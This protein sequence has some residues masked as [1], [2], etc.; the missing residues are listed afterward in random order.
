MLILTYAQTNA[1]KIDNGNTCTGDDLACRIALFELIPFSTFDGDPHLR[2]ADAIERDEF[3]MFQ[4]V[5]AVAMDSYEDIN[6]DY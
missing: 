6:V 3:P 2:F 5:D 4:V 1:I